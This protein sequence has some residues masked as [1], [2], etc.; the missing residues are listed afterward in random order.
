MAPGNQFP[1]FVASFVLLGSS[2]S[3]SDAIPET[4]AGYEEK[5]KLLFNTLVARGKKQLYPLHRDTSEAKS[6]S[7]PTSLHQQ[8]LGMSPWAEVGPHSWQEEKQQQRGFPWASFQLSL[9]GCP[10][11]LSWGEGW[12]RRSIPLRRPF[13][14]AA[15]GGSAGSRSAPGRGT[16]GPGGGCAQRAGGERKL[17]LLHKNGPFEALLPHCTLLSEATPRCPEAQNPLRRRKTQHPPPPVT[18]RR[19]SGGKKKKGRGGGK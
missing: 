18:H 9:P 13:P 7:P 2:Q 17:F 6:W 8:G 10:W 19:G 5:T 15:G 12:M 3:C 1:T 11:G 16:R 14:S 4:H